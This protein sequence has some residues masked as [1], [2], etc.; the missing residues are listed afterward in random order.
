MSFDRAIFFSCIRSS[1]FAGSLSQSQVDG[2]VCILDAFERYLPAGDI[3]F[4]AYDLATAYHETDRTMQPIEEIG[5]GRGHAYGV[6]T[7]PWHHVYDG[8]GFDQLT[9]EQN[10]IHATKRLRAC[11]VIGNDV[12]LDR[13]PELAMRPDIAAAVLI[14]GNAEGWF[15]GHG[16]ND[17]FNDKID[18][19]VGARRVVNGQDRAGMIASYY[20]AFCQ[21]LLTA[22]GAAP[23]PLPNVVQ[24][25]VKKPGFWAWLFSCL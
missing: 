2:I 7:G 19:P 4:L 1:L 21:A 23:K 5:K 22:R 17:Y 25:P 14:L 9:W 13:S 11:G 10:Y 24:G 16:L 3:R 18:D 8:R 6:P 12:D 20:R 15:T